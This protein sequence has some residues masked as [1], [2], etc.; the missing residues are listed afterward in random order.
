M[1]H[2][3]KNQTSLALIVIVFTTIMIA[4]TI[5]SYNDDLAFAWR[6]NHNHFNHFDDKSSNN[7][8]RIDQSSVQRQHSFCLTAGFGSPVSASCNNNA[9]SANANTGGN[10]ASSDNDGN[11][12]THQKIGQSGHQHQHAFCITAGI[13]SPITGSC[14]NTA[15]HANANT[16]GND[17]ASGH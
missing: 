5:V 13:S 9:A 10:G 16:G 14:N 15:L 17:A 11:S 4:G 8:Q 1:S 2:V 6:H 3:I 12:G 7:H